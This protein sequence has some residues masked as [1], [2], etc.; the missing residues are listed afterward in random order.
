M[1]I[2]EYKCPGCGHFFEELIT[3]DLGR[4]VPCPACGVAETEKR[5]SAIGGVLMKSGLPAPSC[6]GGCSG[7]PSCAGAC[8]R[9]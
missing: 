8:P 5:M 2:Y 6:G 1:P 7:A 9:A 3:G 4:S